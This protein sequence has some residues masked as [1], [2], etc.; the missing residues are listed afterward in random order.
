MGGGGI[1]GAEA[2]WRTSDWPLQSVALGSRYGNLAA[3]GDSRGSWLWTTFLLVFDDLCWFSATFYDHR[4]LFLVVGGYL[5]LNSDGPEAKNM[6]KTNPFTFLQQVRAEAAKVVWPTRNETLISTVMVLVMIALASAFFLA[7]DQ[8]IS[9][10]VS[11][12]LSI[13]V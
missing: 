12:V 3:R 1:R 11:L 7:A 10:L 4:R 13:R 8:L 5:L 9:F 6:A 2:G